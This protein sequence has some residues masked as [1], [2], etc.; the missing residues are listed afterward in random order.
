[1]IQSNDALNIF[2]MNT[3]GEA[4]LCE[5]LRSAAYYFV[6]SCHGV[7]TSTSYFKRNL[8]TESKQC[9]MF[10][11]GTGLDI[12]LESYNLDYD[13]DKLRQSFNYYLRKSA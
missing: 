3:I 11:Q 9:F 6:R 5:T 13:A 2:F 1:M 7:T 8:L 12:I 10:I 4:V